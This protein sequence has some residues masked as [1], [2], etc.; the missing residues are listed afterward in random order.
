MQYKGRAIRLR[1]YRN[2]KR[3]GGCTLL[4][5][6]PLIDRIFEVYRWLILARILLTWFPN[7]D[8][9][10]P[11]V[12]FLHRITEPILRPFR[13]LIPNTS[14]IDFSPII[15]FFVLRIVQQIVRSALI[16]L[17]IRGIL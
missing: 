4:F 15:V 16:Q 8:P 17:A 11:I 10:H 7:M 6:I 1:N 13:Q 2:A 12:I 3:R 5:I 9:S 14:G